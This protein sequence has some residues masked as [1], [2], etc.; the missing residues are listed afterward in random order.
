[1]QK[2]GDPFSAQRS[3]ISSCED[4]LIGELF[5]AEIMESFPVFVEEMI[6]LIRAVQ[7]DFFYMER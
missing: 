7:G 2:R 6:S 4:F 5:F 1:M 3:L